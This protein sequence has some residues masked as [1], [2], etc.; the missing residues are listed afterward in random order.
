M[1]AQ[2]ILTMVYNGLDAHAKARQRLE[3]AVGKSPEARSA[4]DRHNGAVGALQDIISQVQELGPD[5]WA[6]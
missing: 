4:F 6:D 1:E 5:V 2:T 3:P